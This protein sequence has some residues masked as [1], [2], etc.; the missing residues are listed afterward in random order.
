MATLQNSVSAII[1]PPMRFSSWLVLAISLTTSLVEATPSK[2]L[3]HK[4][5]ECI[6][7]PR[8]WVK[9]ESAPADLVLELRIALPQPNFH[10]LE[11]H[12]YEVSD[13][14]HPR[15]GAHLSKEEV[16]A[17]VAPHIESIDLVDGWLTSH[18]FRE[19]DLVRSPA[20]DWVTIRVPV[21][22]AEKMLD[23]VSWL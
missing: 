22:V 2:G 8:G 16:E 13:P 7:H 9:Q 19:G 23:T 1:F 3:V 4:V 21:Q 11:S 17:L 18:G 14:D 20:K 5:K 12:L 6:D 15:Y 10:V